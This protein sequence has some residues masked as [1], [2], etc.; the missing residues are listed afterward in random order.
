MSILSEGY[1]VLK[2]WNYHQ[3]STGD[4]SIC[5]CFVRF[6]CGDEKGKANLSL[7]GKKKK[8]TSKGPFACSCWI[9][10]D[11]LPS[12]FLPGPLQNCQV[13]DWRVESI[14][15]HS[16]S[17]YG[18]MAIVNTQLNNL[19]WSCAVRL[20]YGLLSKA[21]MPKSVLI[22]S[23]WIINFYALDLEKNAF[24]SIKVHSLKAFKS[25]EL[26]SA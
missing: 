1:F 5:F 6:G 9:T 25:G 12:S 20:R 7:Q 13:W 22:D 3:P 21:Y 15:D 4:Q 16:S 24:E 23:G 14:T 19:C 17:R 8:S 10:L 2:K 18:K 26:R 11:V